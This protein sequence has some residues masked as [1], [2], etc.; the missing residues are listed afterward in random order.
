MQKF[1]LTKQNAKDMVGRINKFFRSCTKAYRYID[2]VKI[3]DNKRYI[4]IYNVDVNYI[5]AKVSSVFGIGIAGIYYW[6]NSNL[7]EIFGYG[8]TIYFNGGNSVTIKQNDLGIIFKRII[9]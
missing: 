4:P 5:D 2:T 9:V 1:I 6:Y 3:I 7:V 8:S